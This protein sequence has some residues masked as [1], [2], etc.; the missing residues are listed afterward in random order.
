MGLIDQAKSDWQR[1]S[2]DTNEF[3]IAI[4]IETPT[5]SQSV[6]IVGLHTKH[7]ISFDTDGNLVNSKNAHISF[8]EQ[9]LTDVTYP[10][11]NSNGEVYLQGHKITVK[12]ST[13]GNKVYL[14]HQWHQD[15]TL[16]VILCFLR[17]YE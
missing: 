8:S 11:R 2:A 1:F 13:G 15:E 10:V 5:A 9:Q 6:D 14:I 17:D 7:H 12:D 3:G 4:N 16:G